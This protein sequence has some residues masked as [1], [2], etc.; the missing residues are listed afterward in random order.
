EAVDHVFSGESEE[1][2]VRF[3]RNLRERGPPSPPIL[4]G[5]PCRDMDALPTPRFREY[6]DQVHRVLP[7]MGDTPLWVSYE[8]SRGCWWGQKSHCTFCGLNGVG[9]G[10]REKSADRVVAELTEILAESPSR[11]ICMTDN[12]MPW[13]YHETLIPRFPEEVGDVH[14]FYEQKAN[15]TLAQVKGLW[16]AGS[17][18][19]QPGIEALD[20]DLL[21]LMRKGVQARQNIALLR[22]ARS[23]GM[24]I[25]WNLLWGF[26]GDHADSYHRTL[27]LL[28]KV[29]HL[30]PP[31][32]LTHLAM[33]RFSP[34]F[35]DPEAFGIT[36]LEPLECY[37]EVFPAET[38][39]GRLAYHFR[40][41]YPSGS[42]AAQPLMAAL[43]REVWRW[44]E[45]WAGDPHKRPVLGVTEAGPGRYVLVDTRG[46]DKPPTL[47]LNEAQARA[48]LV[49]GPMARVVAADW[50]IRNDYAADLD[51]WCVPLAVA[52]YPLLKSFEEQG[53]EREASTVTVVTLT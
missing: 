27:D 15:L 4:H 31:N 21:R 49:G 45:A 35:D 12:I 43:N 39:L 23:L 29:R 34:Y 17:R 5:T 42:D 26:P 52:S 1:T 24:A 25:K 50:A 53:A 9:M 3:L 14:I 13:R 19:I 7:A 16:D 47:Y 38:D 41:T 28:P 8:T 37:A 46:L 51:G 18:T 30:C 40:A 32:A 2:F 44:R 36:E 10:F 22:Y 6:F 48:V 11:R 33:D 20:S